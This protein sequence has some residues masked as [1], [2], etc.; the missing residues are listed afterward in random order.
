MVQ[1]AGGPNGDGARRRQVDGRADRLAGPFLRRPLRRR[2]SLGAGWRGDQAMGIGPEDLAWAP[3]GI[4]Q[5]KKGGIHLE[6]LAGF[7]DDE[8]EGLLEAAQFTDGEPDAL[9]GPAGRNLAL[10]D[11]IPLVEGL[12]EASD[13]SEGEGGEDD[14]AR[15][16]DG[17]DEGR[18]Q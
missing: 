1:G 7:V 14:G 16:H 12:G 10:E 5:E 9:E 8:L 11:P 3:F 4:L 13:L 2:A 15:G 17:D 18:V 6:E